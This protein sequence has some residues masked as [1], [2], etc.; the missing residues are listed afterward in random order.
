MVE[1]DEDTMQNADHI[2]DIEPLIHAALM[3]DAPQVPLCRDEC[4]GLCPVCGE[5][6]NEGDCGCGTDELIEEFNREANPFASL[7]NFKFD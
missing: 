4:A 1:H 3:V 6:L 7:A 5:N 2:V